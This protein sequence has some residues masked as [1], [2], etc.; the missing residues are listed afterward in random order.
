MEM[1]NIWKI[2]TFCLEKYDFH[3]Q[4]KLV[5]INDSLTEDKA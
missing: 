3:I 1:T 5:K 4:D 2:K